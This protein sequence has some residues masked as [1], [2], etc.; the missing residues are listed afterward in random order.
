MMISR[1]ADKFKKKSLGYKAFLCGVG[2]TGVEFAF[3]MVFNRLFKM[4]VWDYSRM[5]FNFM[6]QICLLYT[7]LWGI[8]SCACIPVAQVFNKKLRG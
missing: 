2:I 3:G 4:N 1:I 5:P 7:L 6:G 8:L